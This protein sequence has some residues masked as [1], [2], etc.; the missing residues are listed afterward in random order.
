MTNSQCTNSEQ[1]DLI[2]LTLALT[3]SQ[4]EALWAHATFGQCDIN[5]NLD[6]KVALNLLAEQLFE[7]TL[8]HVRDSILAEESSIG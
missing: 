2:K 1:S 5:I 4:A 3:E 7:A 8:D 6:T